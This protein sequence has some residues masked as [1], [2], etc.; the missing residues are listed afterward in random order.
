[1]TTFLLLET[2][3]EWLVGVAGSPLAEF[4]FV[5]IRSA[6]TAELCEAV[7]VYC[8]ARDE[9]PGVVISLHATSVVSARFTIDTRSRRDRNAM[10]FELEPTLPFDA[11]DSVADFVVDGPNVIG[12]AV[13]ASKF[14][15]LV[16]QLESR[17]IL[18]QSIVPTALAAV[19]FQSIARQCVAWRSNEAVEVIAW[20]DSGLRFWS[21]LP[22]EPRAV[23]RALDVEEFDTVTLL[24]E[25]GCESQIFPAAIEASQTASASMF[26][27]A[28]SCAAEIVSGN[29]TPWIE[30]R[31]GV[32]ANGDLHRPVQKS[33]NWLLAAGGALL[34]LF[35][36]ACWFRASAYE[37]Q[38]EQF[39]DE[40]QSLFKQVFPTI[41][42][43]APISRLRS[44]HA[45]FLRSRQTNTDVQLP[46][47]AISPTVR[48]IKGMQPERVK[49][50]E[51]RMQDGGVT[52]AVE[53]KSYAD[54]ERVA[55]SM[56]ASGFTVTPQGQEQIGSGRITA[57]FRGKLT[58][59]A[60]VAGTTP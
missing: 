22:D 5:A 35:S 30:L 37:R 56:E 50:T 14:L 28:S 59:P 13:C 46:I 42:T 10:L 19:Q 48:L 34:I 7:S 33:I 44:E 57:S 1:V 2:R 23:A 58:D 12:I 54:A 16:Q 4:E 29:V 39:A 43:N 15:P 38:A 17:G 32:L 26:N 47:S 52:I 41:R 55:K 24:E 3:D 20:N 21:H 27:Q 45:R 49:L 60:T 9:K 11:E 6:T 53:V 36:L 51:L 25:P 40:Q 18:V 31:R 8:S